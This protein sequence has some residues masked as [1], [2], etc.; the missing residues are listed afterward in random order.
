MRIAETMITEKLKANPTWAKS[1]REMSDDERSDAGND[2]A[3]V[4]YLASR[5]RDG[6]GVND[7][8]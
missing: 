3:R 5:S 7:G 8:E 1:W 2:V 4:L 6:K